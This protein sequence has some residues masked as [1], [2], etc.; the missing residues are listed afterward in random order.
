VQTS[1]KQLLEKYVSA[2]LAA[3]ASLGLTGARDA[4]EFW[5]RH[6]LDALKL[7]SLL[8]A[9]LHNSPQKVIDV[10]SGNG[11][12]GIPIAIALP[13][14]R[15]VMLDSNNKKT[16]FLDM[17]CKFNLLQ[18][19]RVISERAEAA[20]HQP[21]YR[22][23]F[24]IAFARAL[25]KLPVALELSLP[26]LKRDGILM[27]PHGPTFK[28]ELAE[29]KTALDKLGGA[30]KNSAAYQL[31]KEITYTALTFLKTRE[32]PEIYPRRVGIPK[33]RPL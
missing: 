8:P 18:N 13:N 33:K 17:F 12:P 15:V 11:T 31:N 7:I 16:G 29:S 32:T 27:I 10:G 5:E 3:P 9:S 23:Y 24:D 20:A 6:V 14:W 30:L 19:V 22:E 21:E 28:K 26:F 4:A 25:G 2:V 1:Q